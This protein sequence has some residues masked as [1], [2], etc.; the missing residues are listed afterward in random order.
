MSIKA[1]TARSNGAQSNGPITPEGKAR[2]S[3]NS[4]KHGLS[5]GQVVLEYESQADYDELEQ[6]LVDHF[7]PATATERELVQE[8]AA[9]R[10]RLRRAREMESAVFQKAVRQNL[11]ALGPDGD[12]AEARALAYAE[13]PDSEAFRMLSRHQGQL[14]RSWEK[15]WNELKNL[16]AERRSVEEENGEEQNEPIRF[17]ARMLDLLTAP[18]PPPYSGADTPHGSPEH[19][20]DGLPG[21]A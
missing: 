3:R 4:L 10:W 9:A 2:S 16:Q 12:P 18:P 8:M 17:T 5:G 15:A 11:E 21:A 13:V 7:H 1:Q 6:S 19:P 20:Y 14:R